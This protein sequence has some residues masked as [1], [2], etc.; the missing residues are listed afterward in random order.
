MHPE[1]RQASPGTCPKCGMALEP[2][3]PARTR[4][5]KWTCPMHPQIVRDAPGACPICGMA[6]EPSE[7][8]S[9][10]ASEENPEL[11]DMTRRF[12]IAVGFS[13]PI[14]VLAMAH[15]IPGAGMSLL[16]ARARTIVELLLA[17]PVC[18]WAA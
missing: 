7:V 8:T 17:T 9:A 16:S 2:V 10:A 3:A 6:L 11:R 1:V 12:W 5:V 14:V 18:V 15:L 13:A 4:A